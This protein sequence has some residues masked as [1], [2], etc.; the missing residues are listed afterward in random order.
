MLRA[1]SSA[2]AAFRIA[3]RSSTLAANVAVS[4][5][6]IQSPQQQMLARHSSSKS[7]QPS[8]SNT[9]QMESDT[10][11]RRV[12]TKVFRGVPTS[13]LRSSGIVLL[14]YCSQNV[15]VEK[16]FKELGLPDTFYSWF[17]VTELHIW[18]LSARLMAEDTKEGKIVRNSM[19]EAFWTDCDRR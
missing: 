9:L 12:V 11:L 8:M 13:L 4:G 5:F 19:I 18:M 15:N 16:F 6:V 3:T 1:A 14:N 2:T 10:L 17:L 7:T